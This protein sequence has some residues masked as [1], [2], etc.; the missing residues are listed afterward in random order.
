MK[1]QWLYLPNRGIYI[2]RDSI[3][4]METY[5][6]KHGTNQRWTIFLN[7]Q[8]TSPAIPMVTVTGDDM[9]AVEEWLEDQ[10]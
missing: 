8:D 5:R 7:L 9:L 1:Q 4:A 2:N 10:P 6:D 3:Y